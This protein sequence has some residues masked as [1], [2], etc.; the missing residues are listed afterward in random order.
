[1][2]L[3]ER[4]L[5]YAV[6]ALVIAPACWFGVVLFFMPIPTSVYALYP[7]RMLIGGWIWLAF[8]GAFYPYLLKRTSDEWYGEFFVDPCARFLV[9]I[10]GMVSG[11][12]AAVTLC[13]ILVRLVVVKTGIRD[14][15]AKEI[16]Y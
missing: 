13:V 2:R 4:G 11:V 12:V 3:S 1:M 14:V 8:T 6:G 16:D 10:L 9:V 15:L 7:W 5:L